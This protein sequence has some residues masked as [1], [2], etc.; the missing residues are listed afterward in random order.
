M[1]LSVRDD[2]RKELSAHL[3]LSIDQLVADGWDP[4]AA[5]EEARRRFG[6]M[7][8][9]SDVCTEIGERQRTTERRR[10]TME[11]LW[12]DIRFGARSL[13]RSPGFAATTSLTLALGIGATAA[14]FTVVNRVLLRPLPYPEPDRIVQVHELSERGTDNAVAGANYRDWRD[15][16]RSFTALAAYSG[17]QQTVLGGTQAVR[18]NV[19]SVSRGF[20]DVFQVDPSLGRVFVDEEMR[21]GAPAAVVVS[22]RFWSL[23]L[24]RDPNVTSRTLDV[25]GAVHQIVGVM[26]ASFTFPDDTEVWFPA[27]LQGENPN[28]TAHNFRVV[29]RLAATATTESA[30]SEMNALAAALYEQFPDNDAAGARVAGLQNELVGPLRQPLFLLFGAAALLLLIACTNIASSLLA[31]GAGRTR[32]MAVRSALGAGRARIMRQLITEN[33]ML[34]AVGATVGLGLAFV[35]VRGLLSLGT[36][37][38]LGGVAV[39]PD[40]WVVAFAAGLAIATAL[41]F[42]L[43][44]GLHGAGGRLVDGLRQGARGT[45][46]RAARTWTMLIV[47]ETALAVVLMVGSGLLVRSF[48]LLLQTD[49]GFR[50]ENVLSVDLSLPQSEYPVVPPTREGLEYLMEHDHSAPV[51]Y[52]DQL[53]A[54]IG[55]LPGIRAFGFTNYLPLSGGSPNGQFAIEGRS[56]EEAGSA[57]YRIVSP[58]YFEAMSIPLIRGRTIEAQDVESSPDVMVIN[59]A[60]ADRFFP[61]EDPIG[62]RIQTGGMDYHVFEWTTIVGI[63][64]DVRHRGLDRPAVPEYFL[65]YPQ[66]GD[67]IGASTLVVRAE[68]D[69]GPLT[70]AIRQRVNDLDPDVPATYATMSGRLFDSVADRRFTMLI[71][72]GFAAAG[73]ALALVGIYGVVSYAVAQQTR[74]L[75]IRMALGATPDRVLGSV[76][77]RSMR[78]VFVGLVLGIV[79]ALLFGRVLASMLVNIGPR[80]PAVFAL[81]ALALLAAGG[82]ASYLPARRITRIDPADSLQAE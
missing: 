68:G 50:T 11:S 63:V 23:W 51:Q 78:V 33:A 40:A 34:S 71:L 37:E 13:L 31:R 53:L 41:V 26:P 76:V 18:A 36:E 35:L 15:Q 20:F 1:D 60:M 21:E 77:L 22:E 55:T 5:E 56:R 59:Q 43:L 17:Y 61:G 79:G 62:L 52:Y 14:I 73:L 27:E 69:L 47:A 67:R 64:G 44:P 12:Q 75:G 81:A 57:Y 6:D 32:E 72:A 19:A 48:W 25:G 65:A 82:L 66:R 39:R 9:V 16:S 8:A 54:E 10:M 49:P 46:A 7:E 30:D 2:V 28:R 4:S 74:E 24:D 70:A 45:S 80:D 3:Q 42:G 58:G 38:T 29:G